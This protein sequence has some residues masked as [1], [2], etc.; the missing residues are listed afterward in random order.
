MYHTTKFNLQQALFAGVPIK[1]AGVTFI[2]VNS[3]ELESGT[4][5]SFNVTGISDEG[6]TVTVCVATLD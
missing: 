4:R 6:V 5:H 2:M 3:I 1:L